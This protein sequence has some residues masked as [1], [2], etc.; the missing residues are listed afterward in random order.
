MLRFPVTGQLI[1][2][3]TSTVAK[4]PDGN[5][6]VFLALQKSGILEL[7]VKEGEQTFG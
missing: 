7:L 5:G 6:G 4:A 1:L 2:E 3:T